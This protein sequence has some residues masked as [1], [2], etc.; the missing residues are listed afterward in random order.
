MKKE[1]VNVTLPAFLQ[2]SA[3]Y[4]AFI[5]NEKGQ[6]VAANQLFTTQ[7]A[8]SADRQVTLQQLF[9]DNSFNPFLVGYSSITATTP[10]I[11][12]SNING[13]NIRWEIACYNSQH[14]ICTGAVQQR[15]TNFS[16]HTA[17]TFSVFFENSPILMWVTDRDGRLQM[18]NKR[19]KE[20]TGFDETYL[21]KS[22]WEAYPK[23]TAD[24][25][26]QN[27]D[28][29]L[30]NNQLLEIEEEAVDVKGVKR[31][32]IAYKFPMYMEGKGTVVAGCSIDVT[33]V[34]E[35][36]NQINFQTRLLDSIEQGVF[37][38]N[39]QTKFIYWSKFAEEMFGWKQEQIL[40]E[41]V[42]VLTA[43]GVFDEA[44][45]GRLDNKQGWHGE[46]ELK[47]KDG[48]IIH[49]HAT[50]SPVLDKNGNISAIIGVCKDITERKVVHK[51]LV[52]QN[53]QFRQIARLQSH[54]VRRPLANMLGLIDLIQYY[55]DKKEY[56]EVLYMIGMLKQSSEDL[57][58][59]IRR[60]VVKAGVYFD[61]ELRIA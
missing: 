4:L 49:V 37:I 19:Y 31:S 30:Q 1:R 61:P 60:I 28:Y 57:D 15:L 44:I 35:K 34:I 6:I 59:I 27:D 23:E 16:L 11:V 22:I 42:N 47:R 7:N 10:M 25:F 33:D 3:I 51:K 13:N 8:V 5:T 52:K 2:Q 12:F 56:E 58:D 41:D 26:K 40:N 46:I 14:F 43:N 20:Y 39:P 53:N 21:G 18:M 48:S 50:T 36:T 54:A 24:L 9:T 32:Y 38:L 17:N 29:V 45:T 55:A